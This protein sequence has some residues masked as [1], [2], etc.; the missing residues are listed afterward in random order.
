M[1][2]DLNNGDGGRT[3]AGRFLRLLD[4]VCRGEVLG[5]YIVGSG[6]LD[7][8]RLGHSDIDVIAVMAD[9]CQLRPRKLWLLRAVSGASE[10][11][12]ALLHR[13]PIKSGTVNASFVRG[14]DLA[15]RV[16]DIE[17]LGSFVGLQVWP[18]KAFDVNPVMWFVLATKGIAMR[19]QEGTELGLLINETERREW[20][21]ANL[22]TYWKPWAEKVLSSGKFPRMHF[23]RGLEWGVSGASRM[24]CTIQTGD[25]I[26]KRA[27][28]TYAQ[29]TFDSRWTEVIDLAISHSEGLPLSTNQ[30]EHKT[31]ARTA[32][33]FVLHVIADTQTESMHSALRITP[34]T[35]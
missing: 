6:A 30:H 7:A 35:E 20:T 25:V 24:H 23:A 14:G 18:A 16:E 2:T 4:R 26:S 33:G 12:D 1:V 13:R 8:W 22:L 15:K 19:G 11:A 10:A 3:G 28:L 27:S 29:Q 32:A 9:T 21:K 31:L 17:P 5:L 34:P